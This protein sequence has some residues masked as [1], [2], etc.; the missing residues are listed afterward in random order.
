MV[1]IEVMRVAEAAAQ[2]RSNVARVIVG[3]GE[4]ITL[5]LVPGPAQCFPRSAPAS[6]AVVPPEACC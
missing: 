5:L 4:A 1:E 6:C 3:K 2:V